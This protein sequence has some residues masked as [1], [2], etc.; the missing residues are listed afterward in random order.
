M[1]G[2]TAESQR[3]RLSSA[4][5]M[6]VQ[7]VLRKLRQLSERRTPRWSVHGE[8][9]AELQANPGLIADWEG[10]AYNRERNVVSIL[11]GRGMGKTTVLEEVLRRTAAESRPGT[12]I[13]DPIIPESFLL[14]DHPIAWVAASLG[15]HVERLEERLRSAELDSAAEAL[16]RSY[17]SFNERVHMYLIAEVTAGASQSETGSRMVDRQVTASRAGYELPASLAE[18]VDALLDAQIQL[19]PQASEDAGH[20]GLLL[21]PF[22][23]VDLHPAQL[24]RIVQAIP[25]LVA[26]PAVVVIFTA[27]PVILQ[28]QVMRAFGDL[29]ESEDEIRVLELTHDQLRKRFPSDLRVTLPSF[30]PR[31]R[32]AFVPAGSRESLV[33]VLRSVQIE[34]SSLGPQNLADFFDM[35]WNFESGSAPEPIFRLTGYADMLPDDPRSLT[36]LHGIV[37]SHAATLI[38]IAEERPR[39]WTTAEY[40]DAFFRL[41]KEFLVFLSEKYVEASAGFSEFYRFDDFDSQV[42]V[43]RPGGMEFGTRVGHGFAPFDNRDIAVDLT[44]FTV[45]YEGREYSPAAAG[46]FSFGLELEF[47]PVQVGVRRAPVPPG[48]VN[49]KAVF[50]AEGGRFGWPLPNIESYLIHMTRAA[51]WALP[52]EESGDALVGRD[53]FKGQEATAW[54]L[55]LLYWYIS[56]VIEAPVVGGLEIRHVIE[57]DE[58]ESD[59]LWQQ[60]AARVGEVVALINELA[61]GGSD[62]ALTIHSDY[63]R[64]ILRDLS[65][66]TFEE[67]ARDSEVQRRVKGLRDAVC[68]T[69]AWG[70]DLM[71]EGE[72]D[73]KGYLVEARRELPVAKIEDIDFESFVP[74]LVSGD[75]QAVAKAMYALSTDR[76][77]SAKRSTLEALM[78][79]LGHKVP[80]LTESQIDQRVDLSQER[81]IGQDDEHGP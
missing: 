36:Q 51:R 57:D 33:D 59:A 35:S 68:K 61:T 74:D 54:R 55:R 13:L 21:V 79:T 16:R 81:R 42:I 76:T 11:G 18:L 73:A 22:D 9:M 14:G 1:N 7:E 37:S 63:F 10:F 28:S 49:D 53:K 6:A 12:V 66:M 34:R 56:S 75:K 20:R 15:P 5:E 31:E 71:N 40:R 30:N 46:L 48:R 25:I 39:F 80:E 27:D 72:S 78:R 58:L 47:L 44:D 38:C 50:R 19:N 17:R 2:H 69:M 43:A 64:W 26:H 60:L 65:W 70:A 62:F 3:V 45:D 23:D 4:Q 77:R 52:L 67:V 41:M 32:L 24:S 8:T 29:L